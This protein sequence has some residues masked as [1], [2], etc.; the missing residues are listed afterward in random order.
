MSSPDYI[1]RAVAEVETKFRYSYCSCNLH[2]HDRLFIA[3]G[4]I[5][6]ARAEKATYHALNFNQKNSLLL[7]TFTVRIVMRLR[8]K[9]RTSFLIL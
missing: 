7:W 4:I 3:I 2:N 8:I 9:S 5:T 1:S 6:L